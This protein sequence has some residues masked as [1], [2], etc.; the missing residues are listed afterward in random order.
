M[1]RAVIKFVPI[2]LCLSGCNL[3]MEQAFV[4]SV[5]PEKHFLEDHPFTCGQRNYEKWWNEIGDMPLAKLL[6][7]S[8]AN[9]FKI[10]MAKE[11]LRET[12]Y[13]LG[14]SEKET[15]ERVRGSKE[16]ILIRDMP[17]GAVHIQ[18]PTLGMY[19]FGDR[20]S[21]SLK[22]MPSASFDL[23]L[24]RASFEIDFWG[25]Q[26][27]YIDAM[28]YKV[29]SF[30]DVVRDVRSQV[31]AQIVREYVHYRTVSAR[32]DCLKEA[33][34]EYQRY[35]EIVDLR[36]KAGLENS[37]EGE[38][39]SI[40]KQLFSTKKEKLN[41]DLQR[42]LHNLSRLTGI[43]NLDGIK[44]LLGGT[45]N[46]PEISSDIIAGTPLE[47]IKN[48]PD[49]TYK[50]KML[51][52]Q[53]H[54]HG[55]SV[56]DRMPKFYMHSGLESSANAI[57]S[58]LEVGNVSYAIGSTIA[59]NFFQQWKNYAR[60]LMY[61]SKVRQATLDYKQCV[62][63]A[64]AEI[65]DSMLDLIAAH[66]KVDRSLDTNEKMKIRWKEREESFYINGKD[67]SAL[68]GSYITYWKSE[69]DLLQTKEREKLHTLSLI[70]ALGG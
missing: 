31:R 13:Q 58:L 33:K 18:E 25:R 63:D 4:E 39:I 70:R 53:C 3:Q 1:S 24:F 16:N 21:S 23:N 66:K 5:I 48:R 19:K 49:L 15:E 45:Y 42:S 17:D 64:L 61:R 67:V 36:R 44:E 2:L 52:H 41:A 20:L 56:A 62:T 28:K 29:I 47:I 8:L 7:A 51:Q 35:L 22:S 60:S 46:V 43:T 14:L 65:G 57:F 69:D 30:E 54:M 6:A 59:A 27:H 32:L 11:R 40:A 68:L 34:K 37:R 50:F 55:M 10:E 12:C 26:K 9:N 38:E